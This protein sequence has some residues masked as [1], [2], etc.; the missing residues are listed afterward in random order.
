MPST[1]SIAIQKERLERYGPQAAPYAR[2]DV[3]LAKWI[4]LC[5]G[6]LL[7]C[8]IGGAG[9][10]S[11]TVIVVG[12]ATA[13]IGLILVLCQGFQRKQFREALSSALGVQIGPKRKGNIPRPPASRVKYEHWCKQYGLRPYPFRGS[14]EPIG[15][16]G[17]E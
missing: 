17:S 7:G 14:L 4:L 5:F 6:V 15:K 10:D 8:I 3:T 11:L 9:T 12:E 2:R 13:G 16:N 1:V